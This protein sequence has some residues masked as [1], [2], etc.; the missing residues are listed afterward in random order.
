MSLRPA[1][2]VLVFCAGAAALSWELLW[3]HFAALALG[4]SAGGTAIVLG[5]TA[6]RV[7]RRRWDSPGSR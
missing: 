3:Q 7:R 1:A 5:T 4:V 2:Y 6:G